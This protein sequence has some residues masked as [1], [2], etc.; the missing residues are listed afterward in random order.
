MQNLHT[1]ANLVMC[2]WLRIV[3]HR[4]TSNFVGTAL[5]FLRFPSN[6][7]IN[8]RESENHIICILDPQVKV[9]SL[10]INLVPCLDRQCLL[11]SLSLNFQHKQYEL[12]LAHLSRR[13]KG[14]LIVYRSIR[15]P[16]VRPSVGKHFQT[17]ISPQPV[18]QS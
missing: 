6:V 4:D 14:E 13:L 9:L 7:F 17:R 18:G 1:Y 16:C 3:S 15:R 12:F 2:T 10:S 11:S 8:I 5:F